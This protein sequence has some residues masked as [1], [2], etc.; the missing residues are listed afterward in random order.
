MRRI[1]S[2]ALSLMLLGV[3]SGALAGET[4]P[5]PAPPPP[6]DP[7]VLSTT[8]PEVIEVQSFSYDLV[9]VACLLLLIL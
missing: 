5:A 2:L 1:C 7:I 3:T 4:Q 8:E 9:D 6:P